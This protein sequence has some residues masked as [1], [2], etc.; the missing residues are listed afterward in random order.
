VVFLGLQGSFP[1]LGGP[2]PGINWSGMSPRPHVAP[3]RPMMY[4]K[5]AMGMGN[6]S[7]PGGPLSMGGEY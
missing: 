3:M 2:L 4:G 1:G 6:I 5:Y 7:R